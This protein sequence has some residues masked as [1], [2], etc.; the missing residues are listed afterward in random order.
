MQ[1]WLAYYWERISSS[2]WFMPVLM[3]LAAVA[4][5]LLSA[6]GDDIIRR[7]GAS[8]AFLYAG[9]PESARTLLSTVAGSMMTVAGVAFSVTMVALSLASSQFGPHLLVNFMRD[10]GNQVVLGAFIG[11]FL[12]C[13]LALGSSSAEAPGDL[14]LS[15]SLAVL[16]ASASLAALIYFIHH[17]ASSMQADYVV[18]DVA[19]DLTRALNRVFPDDAEQAQ[20]PCELEGFEA[21][22]TVGAARSGYLQAIDQRGLIDLAAE[23]DLR[24]EVHRRPGHFLIE[25]ARLVTVESRRDVDEETAARIQR[26]FIIGGQRT[27]EQDPEYGVHQLVEVA[28]RALSPGINDPF[29][30][31]TCI[32]RLT[33]AL[34]HVAERPMRPPVRLDAEGTPRV[35][36]DPIQ[37]RGVLDAAFNQIRQL[38]A[39][40]PAV[41]IRLMEGLGNVAACTSFAD[42]KAAVDTHA[43]M[44]LAECDGKFAPEDWEVLQSR[45][46]DLQRALEG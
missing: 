18:N 9:D 35:Q 33:G 42:R 36:L 3:S 12:F 46:Q 16:L 26:C 41:A 44:V 21:S 1:T 20:S 30:A 19:K 15:T 14:A 29:T 31:I 13:L 7:S 6:M 38:S 2:L 45:Y 25:G 32:D 22:A 11:T 17:I 8:H 39:D 24:L 28:V 5:A 23:A 34:C 40:L 43:R 37:F 10:R 27:A 4:L